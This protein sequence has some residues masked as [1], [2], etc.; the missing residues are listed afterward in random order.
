MW[1]V[2]EG[3]DGEQVLEARKGAR[4]EHLARLQSL[5]AQGRE[6]DRIDQRTRHGLAGNDVDRALD[7]RIDHEILA[8]DEADGLDRGFDVGID[9]VEGDRVVR[10]GIGD[11]LPQ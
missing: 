10:R 5:L 7:L 4:G 1:Y 2:I 6:Q 3:Y 8:R 9:E 11:G